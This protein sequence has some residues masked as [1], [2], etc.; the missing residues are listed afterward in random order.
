M[1]SIQ[2]FNLENEIDV[3]LLRAGVYFVRLQTS[4]GIFQSKLIVQQ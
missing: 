2:N 1:L 4:E 3:S